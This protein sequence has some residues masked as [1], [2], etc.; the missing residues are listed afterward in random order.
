M[1]LRIV[2]MILV[3]ST[4][5]CWTHPLFQSPDPAGSD[6]GWIFLPLL[7]L[8]APVPGSSSSPLLTN[9]TTWSG[10]RLV[11]D[12]GAQGTY[13]VNSAYAPS[14]IKLGSLYMMWYTGISGGVQRI[15]DRESTD[16]IN[17]TNHQLVLNIGAS[18]TG[19]MRTVRTCPT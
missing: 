18:G 11:V 14:V 16:G 8:L 5:A 2:A 13:D 1:C 10:T 6:D 4:A 7:A 15:L 19:T 9:G 17:W 12:A 3:L